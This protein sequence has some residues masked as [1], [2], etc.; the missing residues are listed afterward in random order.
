[1]N[2]GDYPDVTYKMVAFLKVASVA[3]SVSLC[4]KL[5][6]IFL[7]SVATATIFQLLKSTASNRGLCL[8]Q[9]V[10]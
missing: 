3:Y 7:R 8:I 5:A 1:M 6:T 4:K 2:E 10:V 9:G